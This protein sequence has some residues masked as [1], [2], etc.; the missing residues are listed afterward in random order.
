MEIKDSNTVKDAF[1]LSMTAQEVK[2]FMEESIGLSPFQL[3]YFLK[4]NQNI[5]IAKAC[6]EFLT[7]PEA[8]SMEE[9]A[10][11][12]YR[13]VLYINLIEHLKSEPDAMREV[14]HMILYINAQFK[15]TQVFTH[16]I[17]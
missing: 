7:R 12:A 13:N 2:D 8:S 10:G 5:G 6:I 3:F 17:N 15:E 1:V 14:L 16:P 9:S 11:T 4:D